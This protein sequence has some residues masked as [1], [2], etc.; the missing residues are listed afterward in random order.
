MHEAHTVFTLADWDT[1]NTLDPDEL[2]KLRGCLR[3]LSPDLYPHPLTPE[4]ADKVRATSPRVSP[5]QLLQKVA[6]PGRVRAA[7]GVA[8]ARTAFSVL[9]EILCL[10]SSSLL[11]SRASKQVVAEAMDSNDDGLIDRGE[12]IDFIAAQAR[13]VGERPML[14][15]MQLLNVH[16]Q[17]MW[18]ANGYGPY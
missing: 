18:R 7:S 11:S 1:S 9:F 2:A 8:L 17:P 12:W 14:K 6:A 4:I 13:K 16:L 5:N 3:R 15:L 10:P